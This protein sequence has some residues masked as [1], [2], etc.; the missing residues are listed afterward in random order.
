MSPARKKTLDD[1]LVEHVT[2]FTQSDRPAEIIHSNV[3]RMFSEVV[4]EAFSPHGAFASLL[5]DEFTKAL[6]ANLTDIVDLPTYNSVMIT[7]LKNRWM[8][9]GVTGD[10]LRRAEEAI[11]EVLLEDQMP[12]F[13]SLNKLIEAFIEVNQQRAVEN[14]WHVPHIHILEAD[15]FGGRSR[16]VHVFFDAEPEDAFRTRNN[17]LDVTRNDTEYANRLSVLI[18]GHT[19]KGQEYGQVL[20]AMMENEPIG[21]KFPMTTRWQRLV[22]ALYFGHSKVVID[23][24]EEDFTYPL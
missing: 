12:E 13:I 21:R 11:H 3:E 15:G 24:R 17:L 20:T 23:C 9:S 18:Q 2:A 8:D 10:F 1:L 16:Y 19:D 5:K 6:P 7:A 22:A 14:K 4:R